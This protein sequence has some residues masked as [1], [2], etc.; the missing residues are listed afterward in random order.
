MV[1]TILGR[2]ADVE[3]GGS[4]PMML[5]QGWDRLG[6]PIG[7]GMSGALPSFVTLLFYVYL[8]PHPAPNLEHYQV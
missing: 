4:E 1:L 7:F 3:P 2:W 8:I 6:W 5:T